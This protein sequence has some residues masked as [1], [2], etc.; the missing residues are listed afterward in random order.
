ML[1]D[2][3]GRLRMLQVTILWY[4]LF[5]CLSGFTNSFEQLF[6][7]R[8]LQGFGYGGEWVA[9]AVLLGEVI[10]GEVSGTCG[11]H[12]PEWIRGR[13]GGGRSSLFTVVHSYA[14]RVRLAHALLDRSL[15]GASRVLDT[16]TCRRIASVCRE[17]HARVTEAGEIAL[18]VIFDPAHLAVTIKITVFAIGAQ[19]GYTTIAI[20]LPAY[21]RNERGTG[22]FLLILII[23]AFCGFLIGAF[24]ADKIGRKATFVVSGTGAAI[25]SVLYTQLSLS[26]DVMILL[27]IPLG[28]FVSA[29]FAPIGAFMTEMYPTEVRGTGQGFCYN[30]GRGLGSLF[31]AFVGFFSPM[32]S[33][34]MAIAGFSVCVYGLMP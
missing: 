26:D 33:L 19:G 10:R 30:A 24:L 22:N 1:S 32:I 2:R 20:W 13:L 18:F 3:F 15:S 17:P 29:A 34:G 23:G 11:R 5:T 7:C 21:L 8:T 4:A 25:M 6:I 9:G 16:P 28:L 27:G 12:R 31:P 14:G